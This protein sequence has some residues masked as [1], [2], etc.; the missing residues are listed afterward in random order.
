M[1]LRFVMNGSVGDGG[2][3]AYAELA[4]NDICL[5][6]ITKNVSA[7]LSLFCQEV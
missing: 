1:L 3:E 5:T 6:H 4:K 2:V 7:F